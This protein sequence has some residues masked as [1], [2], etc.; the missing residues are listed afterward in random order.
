MSKGDLIEMDGVITD[1]MGGGFY[2]VKV[3]SSS[4]TTSS[5]GNVRAKLS[6]KMK[7]NKVRVM[8]GDGVRIAVSPYDMSHGM[9]VYRGRGG[10][11]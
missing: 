7:L 6:G 5:A 1:A 2:N 8:P 4:G 3:D 9:I 10:K 11:G